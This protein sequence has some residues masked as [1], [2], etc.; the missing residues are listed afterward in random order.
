MN[1]SLLEALACPG[2]RHAYDVAPW[3]TMADR[4]ATGTLRCRGCGVAVPLAE[5]FALFNEAFVPGEAWPWPDAEA[6]AARFFGDAAAYARFLEAKRLR[7]QVD[8]YA[9]FQPFNE[10]TRALYP[11]LEVLRAAL[12]PGD[13]ILDTWGRTG[14][15]GEL[16][17][18]LFPEQ[19][20]VSIWEGDA[21][22]L[23]YKGY[24]HWLG[25]GRRAA[26][27]EVVFAS[28][29]KPLPFATGAFAAVVGLDS[30][31][32]YG[33][34][35]FIPECLRV[36][37]PDGVLVFPHVHMDNSR[38]DPYFDRG[39]TILHG[40]TWRRYFER[41]L[42]DTPR[43]AFV[44]S[45]RGLFADSQTPR[46]LHDDAE[47]PDYNGLIL[48]ADRAWEGRTLPVWAGEP[49]RA[50][51]RVVVNPVMRVD[52]AT[53]AIT[54]D[55]DAMAGGADHLLLRHPVYE[56]RLAPLSGRVLTPEAH[57]VYHWACEGLS[58]GEIATRLSRPLAAVEADLR[59]LEAH[60]LVMVTNVSEAM[61]RLHHFY[62]RQT[63]QTPLSEHRFANL[64]ASFAGR[65]GD[66]PVL[67][68]DD[69]GAFGV[70]EVTQV[71]DALRGLYAARGLVAGEAIALWG[72]NHVESVCA[73]WA[74]MLSGLVTVVIDSALPAEA[75][76]A[77]WRRT[78]ARL[79][80]TDAP[81][82]S[83]L[84]P[85]DIPVVL[86]DP[87]GEV[88]PADPD[89]Q[90]AS[91]LAPHFDQTP[92]PPAEVGEETP[93]A[94]LFTSGSTG[95]PKAVVL[96]QGALYR[97]GRLLAEAY[98]WGPQDVL[99]SLG[100]FH[101][102][103]GLRNP[104][105]AG[106]HA[107]ATLLVASEAQR[108]QPLLAMAWSHEQQ[109]TVLSTVP[110]FLHRALVVRERLAP[111]ALRQILCTG[112]QLPP[113]VQTE[114]EA[115]FGVPVFDYYGLTETCGVCV[116]TPPDEAR[117]A[118]GSAGIGRPAGAIARIVDEHGAPV[119]PGAIGE[120][121][122]HSGNLMVGYADQPDLSDAMIRDGWLR[123]GDSAHVRPDGQI[124]LL[125]RRDERIKT[126]RGEI[127]Y[128]AE[129]EVWLD[130]HPHVAEVAVVPYKDAH[131]DA[132]LAAFVVPAAGAAAEPGALQRAIA[133]A[134]GPHRAPAHLALVAELPRGSN[135]KIL[136]SRLT[137][138][139]HRVVHP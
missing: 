23:G 6:M 75:A 57:M 117:G 64:W 127:L 13:R 35:P 83:T 15:S 134:L 90:L 128:A 19:R 28:A 98:G 137:E 116:L 62:A 111:G 115:A 29:E 109:A 53:G 24:R 133:D 49:C 22:V 132:Q 31:H 86:L 54:T 37:R 92:P 5:G 81:R 105:L 136:K 135:G 50:G 70:A 78:G 47:T 101:A 80:I 130:G 122:V 93:A 20:I 42:A 131:H 56:E 14:W 52:A 66:R 126:A 77:L 119:A 65:Y 51:S 11:V 18:A 91:W 79:L 113:S 10:S 9:A 114:V 27:L 30:L 96:S 72:D 87:T 120:L 121:W 26:N 45:E 74:A 102:M 25:Q 85:Q 59:L 124:V 125:G 1:A 7:P 95:T 73:F 67:V 36:C 17:A 58:A 68:A 123:T 46:V 110:A 76:E 3:P 61:A 94:V 108:A 12:A 88:E 60:E 138:E 82:V 8:A 103:S 97:S 100:G 55:R 4:P 99:L 112:A 39:G 84:G 44:L 41:L 38:P 106:F 32:R 33:P 118:P 2:C 34:L 40:R 139:L 21:N 89:A 63:V 48:I 69:G 129:L 71:V 107:G 16:L 43:Q 104:C